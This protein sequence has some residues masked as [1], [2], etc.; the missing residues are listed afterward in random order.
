METVME[1]PTVLTLEREIEEALR[2]GVILDGKRYCRHPRLTFQQ[3]NHIAKAAR[4]TGLVKA[5]QGF[6]PI[7]DVVDDRIEGLILEAFV[8]N[9][10]YRLLAASLSEPTV[11]WT[12]EYAREVAE[13]F[14]GL[15]AP[16][17]QA[18]LYDI[19]SWVL[20]DFFLNA[21]GSWRTFL[22]YLCSRKATR[23]SAEERDAGNGT[24][25]S[26]AIDAIGATSTSASGRPSSEPLPGHSTETR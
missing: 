25:T 23:P 22:K 1:V 11:E 21:G 2:D 19:A 7:H 6:D 20:L 10:M 9:S 4:D 5:M 17:D 18:R 16:A 24:S 3:N 12:P 26:D 8:N 15:T 14:K 13:R